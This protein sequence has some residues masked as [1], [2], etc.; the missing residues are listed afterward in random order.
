MRA[1]AGQRER[2]ASHTS[3]RSKRTGSRQLHR[4]RHRLQRA[5]IERQA[6]LR[7]FRASS[8]PESVKAVSRRTPVIW[9]SRDEAGGARRLRRRKTAS[10]VGFRSQ[11]SG[12]VAEPCCIRLRCADAPRSPCMRLRRHLGRDEPR[13]L[14]LPAATAAKLDLV[15]VHDHDASVLHVVSV[16]M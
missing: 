7:R 14:L 8:T 13:V 6:L 3:V 16:A 10:A 2:E 4:R 9:R 15:Y 1:R 5:Q 11:A 12:R